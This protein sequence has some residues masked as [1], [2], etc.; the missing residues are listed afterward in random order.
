[1]LWASFI[2]SRSS[3]SKSPA[4]N[5]E[6]CDIVC[7]SCAGHVIVMWHHT[8]YWGCWRGFWQSGGKFRSVSWWPVP[9]GRQGCWRVP[10]HRTATQSTCSPHL[11]LRIWWAKVHYCKTRERAVEDKGG[12]KEGRRERGREEEDKR[13]GGILTSSCCSCCMPQPQ[14]SPSYLPLSVPSQACTAL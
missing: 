4:E 3:T 10:K 5:I 13:E 12:R 11:E 6:S 7:Q 2:I 1:M 14:Q 9:F 8:T